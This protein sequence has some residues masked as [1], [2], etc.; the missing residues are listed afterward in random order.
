MPRV[1]LGSWRE[2]ELHKELSTELLLKP[3]PWPSPAALQ[4]R[5]RSLKSLKSGLLNNTD[6]RG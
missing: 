4:S 5:S 3:T 1:F 6:V 2:D